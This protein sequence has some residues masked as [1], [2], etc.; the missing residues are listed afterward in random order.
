MPYHRHKICVALWT[1]SAVSRS[2]S[3]EN[4]LAYDADLFLYVSLISDSVW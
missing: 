1:F 4:T 3:I 2:S